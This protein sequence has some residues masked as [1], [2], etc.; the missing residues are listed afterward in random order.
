MIKHSYWLSN[1]TDSRAVSTALQHRIMLHRVT[2]FT[3]IA[4]DDLHGTIIG[5]SVP[6][7]AVCWM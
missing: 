1:T 4:T 3:H 5:P 2:N 6:N 7:K